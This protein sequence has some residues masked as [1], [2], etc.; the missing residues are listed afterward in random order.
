MNPTKHGRGYGPS[1]AVHQT[2]GH[3]AQVTI[4]NAAP[5]LPH[6]NV[7]LNEYSWTSTAM[8]REEAQQ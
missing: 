4:E 8:H 1:A 3:A 7:H 6:C 2:S 5:R